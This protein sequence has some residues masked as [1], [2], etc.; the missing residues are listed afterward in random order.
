MKIFNHILPINSFLK[1][2]RRFV[3]IIALLL[4]TATG[5][6]FAQG[7]VRWTGATNTNWATATNWAVVSGT[8]ST[9]PG[10]A[11]DVQIGTIATFTKEPTIGAATSINSLTYGNVD[12]S[13]LTINANLTIVGAITNTIVTTARVHDVTIATGVILSAGS[14]NLSP[15][16]GAANMTFTFTGTAAFNVTGNFTA[17]PAAITTNITLTVAAGTFTVG[18]TMLQGAAATTARNCVIS[19]TTGTLTFTGAYTKNG[20]GSN[21]TTT[22]AANVTFGGSVTNTLGTFT[23]NAATTAIFTGTTTITPTTAI[24]FGNVQL[25]SGSAVT[26]G[27]NLSVTGNWTNNG[28]TFT[29]GANTVTFSGLT[30]TIGGT[31]NTTFGAITIAASATIT[32][33]N[34]NSCANLTFTA[35]GDASSFTHGSTSILTVSGNVVVNQPTANNTTTAWNINAGSATVAGTTTVGGANAT[36]T[37]IARILVTTGSTTFG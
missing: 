23:L 3:S 16:I 34:N 7:V 17:Q 18:G 26:A 5:E 14:A 9:P 28:G 11:D 21:L 4:L 19:A 37:R 8:P 12:R 10:I 30:G 27:G 22:G 32:M 1:R 6:L 13:T 36:A 25:N 2:N 20:S 15:V 33:N 29:P 35:S 31:T 24:T